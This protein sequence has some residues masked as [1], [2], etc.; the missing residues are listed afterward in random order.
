MSLVLIVNWSGRVLPG[1]VGFL[2]G[3]V[4]SASQRSDELLD[5]QVRF[6]DLR[7]G[8]LNSGQLLGGAQTR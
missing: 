3:M 7:S 4:G 2:I 6:W 8:T 5:T 1:M